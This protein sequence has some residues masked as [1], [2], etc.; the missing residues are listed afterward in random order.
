MFGQLASNQPRTFRLRSRCGVNIA[1][2]FGRFL[3]R[4]RTHFSGF[5]KINLATSLNSWLS[6]IKLNKPGNMPNKKIQLGKFG[7]KIAEKYLKS[8]GY[9]IIAKNFY[10]REGEIDLICQKNGIVFFVEVK[11]RTNQ[12]FGWPEEA[13]TD[14]KLEKIAAAGEKYLTENKVDCEWQID[15]ISIMID[16][17]RKKAQVKHF[18]NIT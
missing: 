11:T 3:F 12:N 4:C 9:K 5:K 14:Q 6:E 18:Q 13:V 10:S 15:I 16:K 1:R 7:E 8:K 2:H 17:S